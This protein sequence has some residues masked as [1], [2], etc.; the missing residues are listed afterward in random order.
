[1]SEQI[2]SAGDFVKRCFG[3]ALMLLMRDKKLKSISVTDIA[4]K[5]GISRMT[6]YRNFASKEHVLRTYMQILTQD[7]AESLGST[8]TPHRD[9]KHILQAVQCFRE[10]LD[11]FTCLEQEG[12]SNILLE[13]I[14]DFLM[15]C[16][17]DAKDNFERACALQ[18]YAGALYNVCM[19]WFRTGME[20]T[21]EEVADAIM[22]AM[23]QTC[24][25]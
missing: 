4:A 15:E 19:Y 13:G 20:E 16:K 8:G 6:Y 22:Y 1:M 7:Y 5:A 2:K 12:L 24:S 17:T 21:D 11:F 10:N 3:Q 9:R 25:V 23:R 14:S 18:Y